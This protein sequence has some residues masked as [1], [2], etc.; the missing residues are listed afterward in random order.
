WSFAGRVISVHEVLL[1]FLM[2]RLRHSRLLHARR[3]RP[4]NRTTG[5]QAGFRVFALPLRD[6]RFWQE[7]GLPA[8]SPIL[9]PHRDIVRYGLFV[10]DRWALVRPSCRIAEA[11]EPQ[12]KFLRC[13]RTLARLND[14][15]RLLVQQRQVRGGKPEPRNDRA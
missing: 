4:L 5:L 10:V 9:G 8:Y 3:P 13:R 14:I 11:T 12:C 6:R 2:D 7:D 15:E 1:S